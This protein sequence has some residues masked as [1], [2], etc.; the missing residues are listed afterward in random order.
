MIIHQN[1]E[2]M[3]ISRIAATSQAKTYIDIWYV[4]LITH[5]VTGEKQIQGTAKGGESASSKSQA[6]HLTALWSE[7][8]TQ[9]EISDVPL[10]AC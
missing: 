10:D 5:F 6:Y 7:E 9:M 4:G 3:K 2:R 1:A 8:T